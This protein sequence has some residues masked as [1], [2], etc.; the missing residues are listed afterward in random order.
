MTLTRMGVHSCQVWLNQKT[1]TGL[2]HSQ[3]LVD[4][5]PFGTTPISATPSLEVKVCG[6]CGKNMTW[7]LTKSRQNQYRTYCNLGAR[8]K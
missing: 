2:E 8:K 6:G 1:G 3:K 5:A 7:H 4:H